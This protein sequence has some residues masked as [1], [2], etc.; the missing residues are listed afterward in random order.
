MPQTSHKA[1]RKEARERE[2]R[3]EKNG[4]YRLFRGAGPVRGPPVPGSRRPAS[5][6]WL[7][8]G[9]GS[10]GGGGAGKVDLESGDEFFNWTKPN[11]LSSRGEKTTTEG[12][13]GGIVDFRKTFRVP[14][15]EVFPRAGSRPG[16]HGG[17]GE[18]S[19]NPSFRGM[20]A[21]KLPKGD[22]RV[23]PRVGGVL[24]RFVSRSLGSG[25]LHEYFFFFLS[26]EILWPVI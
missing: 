1:G 2:K 9:G 25:S 19:R 18:G 4:Y 10:G 11:A 7:P 3:E 16:W 26:L 13:T 17:G 20:R 12:G 22:C 15:A 21:L 23:F 14:Q 8:P 6:R 5:L 24:E